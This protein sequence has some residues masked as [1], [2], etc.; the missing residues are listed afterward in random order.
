LNALIRERETR[1]ILSVVELRGIPLISCIFAIFA[2]SL[3]ESQCHYFKRCDVPCIRKSKISL[4]DFTCQ[5]H[6]RTLSHTPPPTHT[7][8]SPGPPV[9]SLTKPGRSP[10]KI[11]RKNIKL[12]RV[13]LATRGDLQPENS[14]S[15]KRDLFFTFFR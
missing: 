10:I 6:F 4:F 13:W 8:K 12:N 9:H 15:M 2:P 5:F 14:G 11:H 1:C 7:H 3:Q